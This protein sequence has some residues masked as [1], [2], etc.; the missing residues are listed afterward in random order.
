MN[1]LFWN[2]CGS[3]KGEKIPIIRKIIGRNKINFVGLVETK[4]RTSIKRRLKRLWGCDDVEFCESFASENYGGGIITFWDPS[5]F[6]VS[7]KHVSVR[8]IFLEGCVSMTN[9]ECCVGVLYGPNDRAN[10]CVFC[11]FKKPS[12]IH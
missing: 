8:W 5:I 10:R 11:G 7:H 3:G 6:C 12:S 2:I 1:L 9:F 4:H